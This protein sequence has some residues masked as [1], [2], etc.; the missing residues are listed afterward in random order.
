MCVKGS[1]SEKLLPALVL[2]ALNL[3]VQ[4]ARLWI[5]FNPLVLDFQVEV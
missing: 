5:P 1:V 2:F 3:V 4:F